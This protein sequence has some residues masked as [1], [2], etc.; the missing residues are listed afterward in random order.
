M[1][2]VDRELNQEQIG[3]AFYSAALNVRRKKGSKPRPKLWWL[4]C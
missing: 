4:K 2:L 1:K 3:N